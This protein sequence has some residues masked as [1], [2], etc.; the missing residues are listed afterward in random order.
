MIQG[1]VRVAVVRVAVVRVAVVRVAVVRVAMVRV[2]VVRVAQCSSFRA[3]NLKHTAMH[4]QQYLVPSASTEEN[5]NIQPSKKIGKWKVTVPS[6]PP[7]Y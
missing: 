5:L 4:Q 7:A 6:P 1:E 2:A 3:R